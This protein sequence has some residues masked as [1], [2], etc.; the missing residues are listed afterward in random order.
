MLETIGHSQLAALAQLWSRK[1]SG[2]RL[3][4]R[5][6]FDATEL[7]PWL[8]Q[9]MLLDVVDDGRDFRYRLH[10]TNL[11]ELFGGDL[12]GR[13]VGEFDTERRSALMAEYR[14]ALETRSPQYVPN[15]VLAHKQHM[16]VAKLVLPLASDGARIDKLMVSVYS[17]SAYERSL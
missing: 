5:E 7:R 11:V 6:D 15:K 3:P 10:G 4:A 12:T 17:L 1:A 2:K 16:H 9:L 14:R 8:G 13:S